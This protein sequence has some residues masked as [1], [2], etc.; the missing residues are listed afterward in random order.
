MGFRN[1]FE[2]VSTFS[3]AISIRAMI[4][5]YAIFFAGKYLMRIS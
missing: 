4:K 3:V 5:V 2:A 1:I